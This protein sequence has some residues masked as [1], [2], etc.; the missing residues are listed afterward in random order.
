MALTSM[1]RV[2]LDS[3]EIKHP[4]MRIDNETCHCCGRPMV[5]CFMLT[6]EMIDKINK[7]RE[8]GYENI[9]NLIESNPE[10]KRVLRLLRSI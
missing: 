3:Y 4:A 10:F 9:D 2:C 5:T 7:A 1:C 8:S 6:G